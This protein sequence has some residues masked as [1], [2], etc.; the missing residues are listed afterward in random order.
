MDNDM[1][2]YL[3][4]EDFREFL[5]NNGFYATERELSGVM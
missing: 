3:D 4:I 2:G 1:D 5:A